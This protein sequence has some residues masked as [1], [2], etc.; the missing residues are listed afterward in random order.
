MSEEKFPRDDSPSGERDFDHP[1]NDL[2]A[3]A[4]YANL[5][6]PQP[7]NF[8]DLAD[9]IDPVVQAELNRQSTRQA[10]TWLFSIPVATF[11]VAGLLL[12][13]T[14]ALG[15]ERCEAGEAAWLCSQASQIWWPIVTSI[16]PVIGVLGCAVI[17]VRKIRGYTRWRPWMGVFWIMVPFAMIWMTTVLPMAILGGNPFF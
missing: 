1:E 2:S 15:G 5:R 11:L 3:D 16:I 10:F 17:M 4:D 9:S 13:V 6:R 7:R 14:R 8:D 12:L